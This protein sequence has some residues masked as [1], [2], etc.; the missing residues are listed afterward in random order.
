[1]GLPYA[2]NNGNLKKFMEEIE[3]APLPTKVDPSY[4]S[5]RGYTGANDKYV[6]SYL[7]Q[8][9]FLDDT[10]TPT[11]RWKDHRHA[12]QSRSLRAAGLREAYSG[13]FDIHPDAQNKTETEFTHWARV[14]DS[15]ASPKTISRS[16]ASFRTMVPLCDF[17][18]STQT[19]RS[20]AVES[21]NPTPKVTAAP[22]PAVQLGTTGG[23]TINIELQLPATADA[24]FFDDFFTSMRKNLIDQND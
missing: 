3:S 22:N 2:M 18:A 6:V 5:S 21:E 4:L 10:A 8:L 1:M 7:K 16:W 9:G 23:I 14:A 11:Q 13:F 15:S 12:D 17:A 24:S 19:P 20:K